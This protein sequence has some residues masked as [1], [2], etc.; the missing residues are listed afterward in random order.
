MLF[1]IY[2]YQYYICRPIGPWNLPYS[3]GEKYLRNTS[4]S[5]SVYGYR[6]SISRKTTKSTG[7]HNNIKFPVLRMVSTC[8][9]K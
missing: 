6:N 7:S 8:R 9:T 2:D 3:H 5:P 1:F 4:I